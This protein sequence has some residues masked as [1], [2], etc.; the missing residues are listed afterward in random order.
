MY[1]RH[2]ATVTLSN[3]THRL[4]SPSHLTLT[5]YSCMLNN[6]THHLVSRLTL[7]GYSCMLNDRTHRLSR[8]TLTGYSCMLSNRTHRLV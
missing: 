4:V 6:R 3:C 2:T 7:S 8:L 5:G 1:D